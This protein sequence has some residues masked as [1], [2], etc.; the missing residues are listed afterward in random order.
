MHSLLAPVVV[1]VNFVRYQEGLDFQ[2]CR[3]RGLKDR[4]LAA[5]VLFQSHTQPLKFA[6][7]RISYQ[8][9]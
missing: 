2:S 1:C 5:E 7:S 6:S 8:D 9:D 3:S 4:G